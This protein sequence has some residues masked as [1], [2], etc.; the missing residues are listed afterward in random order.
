MHIELMGRK[1]NNNMLK[2]LPLIVC[3]LLHGSEKFCFHKVL[4]SFPV[5]YYFNGL[6]T[7]ASSLDL[8]ATKELIRDRFFK[9]TKYHAVPFPF[10]ITMVQKRPFVRFQLLQQMCLV[11]LSRTTYLN[12]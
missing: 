3:N 1:D 12:S 11:S 4:S 7:I 10:L 5:V 9:Y 8:K 6:I 2:L